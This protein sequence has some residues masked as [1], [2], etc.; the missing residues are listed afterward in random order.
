MGKLSREKG[1]R[2][3][4]EWANLCK[5]YG[6]DCRRTAQFCG[7]TG[8]AADVVGID[9]IHQEVKWVERLKLR[10]AMEQAKRDCRDNIP[11]VAHKKNGKEW[12]VTMRGEDWLEMMK[13]MDIYR[14]NN[15]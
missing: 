14:K 5:Q 15:K 3:E 11:I 1:K 10:D 9:G 13:E 4:R 8:E 2:G 6:F 7:K 12:L